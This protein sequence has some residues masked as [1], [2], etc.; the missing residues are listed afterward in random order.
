MFQCMYKNERIW[1]LDLQ[2]EYKQYDLDK[3]EDWAIAS[4]NGKLICEVCG[5]RLYLKAGDHNRPH[6][7][8][9]AN[10]NRI[11]YAEKLEES[12]KHAISRRDLLNHASMKYPDNLV[13]SW[14]LVA[15]KRPDVSV[16]DGEKALLVIE[17]IRNNKSFQAINEKQVSYDEHGV[18]VIWVLDEEEFRGDRVDTLIANYLSKNGLNMIFMYN[19]ESA[20]MTCV[21]LMTFYTPKNK[22]FAI[23]LYKEQHP[24]SDLG[25]SRLGYDVLGFEMRFDDA[26]E[27]FMIRQQAKFEM[28]SVADPHQAGYLGMK[29]WLALSKGITQT[30]KIRE[31]WSFVFED[32]EIMVFWVNNRT[33]IDMIDENFAFEE[34]RVQVFEIGD[35]R[36]NAAI[37]EIALKDNYVLFYSSRLSRVDIYQHVEYKGQKSWIK[38]NVTTRW[39]QLSKEGLFYGLFEE[40]L[41]KA[42]ITFEET[43]DRNEVATIEIAP[44][45]ASTTSATTKEAYPCEECGVIT[46]E[47]A[48]KNPRT[49]TCICKLCARRPKR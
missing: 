34:D 6:F 9:R 1:S 26:Y 18:P 19:H 31:G 2:N 7:A 23:E 44:M 20:K 12:P 28:A 48:Y 32:N 8:H 24:L 42:R 49:G 29:N 4:A 39:V 3:R 22:L 16:K 43:V 33:P 25:L 15:N 17:F 47:Y 21:R 30:R 10:P 45:E 13:E 14:K 36:R 38:A 37:L 5:D 35:P 11:C 46:D 41:D 27:Q 40:E